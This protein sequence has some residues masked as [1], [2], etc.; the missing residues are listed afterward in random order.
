VALLVCACAA[1]AEPT[2]SETCI[3]ALP[4]ALAPPVFSVDGSTLAVVV[5][6][7]AGGAVWVNGITGPEYDGIKAGSP[8]LST[9]GAHVAYVARK[10]AKWLVVFDGQE[11]LEYDAIGDDSPVLSADGVHVAYAA[12]RGPKAV[13]V[14]D[15]EEGPEYDGTMEGTPVLNTDGTLVAYAARRGEKW[16]VVR[17]GQESP[18]YDGIARLVLSA[19]G[20]HVAYMAEKGAKVVVVSDG[21]EGPE[22]DSL[23]E[24]S[25]VLSADGARVAY[26]AK[27]GAK[28]V[29]VL[30]GQEGPEYDGVGELCLSANGAHVAYATWTRTKWVVVV[31]GEDGPEYDSIGKGSPILSADGAH[32]AYGARKGTKRVVTFDGQEG[33]EYDGIAEGSP[34][35]SADGAHVAYVA[36]KGTKWVVVLDGKECPE[37][38][39]NAGLVLSADGA[40][41]AYAAKR[42][43]KWVVVLDGQEGPEYDGVG[44]L[45]LSADGAYVAY[46]AGKG[47]KSVVMFDGQ[48]GPEYDAICG[49]GP[50][51]EADGRCRYLAVRGTALYRVTVGPYQTPKAAR[52]VA[53]AGASSIPAQSRAE[54]DLTSHLGHTGPGF[55]AGMA[56][57]TLGWGADDQPYPDRFVV[58][59]VDLA[60]MVW[61]PAATFRMGST[62]EE[63]DRQWTDNSWEPR[64]KDQLGNE[65]PQHPVRLTKGFWLYKH[66]VTNAQYGIF[67]AAT[68]HA[69]HP[70]W[71]EYS[72]RGRWPANHVTWDDCAAYARWACGAL[73]T[74]AQWEWS[75]RGPE[76]RAYPWGNTFS[77]DRCVHARWI[78]AGRWGLPDSWGT[79]GDGVAAAKRQVA[80]GSEAEGFARLRYLED[81]GSVPEGASWCGAVDLAGSLW[82]WCSDWY[83]ESYYSESMA[84]A[85]AEDP[86][87]PTAGSERVIRGGS[88]FPFA[89]PTWRS[90]M[91][92]SQFPGDGSSAIGFRL[93]TAVGP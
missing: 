3:G 16:V 29:V 54:A 12:K 41:S 20:A 62:D 87:G 9:D 91:R 7:G 72:T 93:S 25:L 43:A 63:I 77:S 55:A 39:G 32:V 38:D 49:N 27:K 21:Q 76:G 15:G 46:H 35:L 47:T 6:R 74:E 75:A 34:L 14:L 50:R 80:S 86:P 51:F 24:G 36:R 1:L 30:G 42:G 65:K 73:P 11:G 22:Y 26:A 45:C 61:V 44:K 23:R 60:E 89:P 48:E 81:V 37:Y 82:E 4:K 69:P 70:L 84:Q 33:P 28:C 66:E 5:A 90:A 59:P 78:P 18:E 2:L 52:G 68:G 19:D 40:Y 88:W 71:D 92:L 58:N 67:L 79:V 57:S 85:P 13:V 53:G 8:V 10:G 64:W 56:P 17:D 83:G 31:D